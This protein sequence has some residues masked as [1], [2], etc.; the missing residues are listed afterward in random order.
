[1]GKST[2]LTKVF[3]ALADR[4]AV[5]YAGV[6][7]RNAAQSPAELM[8]VLCSQL[9][10]DHFPGFDQAYTELLDQQRANVQVNRC[11]AIFSRVDISSRA[12]DNEPSALI[13]PHLTRKFVDDL[14][15][16]ND[17]MVLLLFDTTEQANPITQSW[18]FN[19]LLGRL[20]PLTHLRVVIAGRQ[21]PEAASSYAAT[22]HRYKLRP[23]LEAEA[24]IRYCRAIGSRLDEPNIRLLAHNSGYT[25]DVFANTAKLFVPQER[26][27][28]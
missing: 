18:L 12:G 16:L 4:H 6:D 8:H 2:F 11:M 22:C 17:R 3:P 26:S 5:R 21:L 28:G 14:R 23:V 10:V 27:H 9:D 24:Y 13:T 25:P 15:G 1:M 7:M 19:D 20:R